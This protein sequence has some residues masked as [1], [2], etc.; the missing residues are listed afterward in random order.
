[1]NFAIKIYKKRSDW[2]EVG[3]RL[4]QLINFERTQN[5]AL[6]QREREIR[7]LLSS[8]D[9]QI[10]RSRRNSY[11][12]PLLTSSTDQISHKFYCRFQWSVAGISTMGG[13]EDLPWCVVL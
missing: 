9:V 13:G 3:K 7:K 5:E 1:M 4:L 12:D 6:Y 8:L 11:Y 2:F 10:T